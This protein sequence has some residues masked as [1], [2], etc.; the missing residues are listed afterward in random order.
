MVNS[1]VVLLLLLLEAVP[2]LA[3]A[4]AQ[5]PEPDVRLVGL[6]LGAH[7]LRNGD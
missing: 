2:H 6:Q 1:P 3:E 5:V 4:A 7:L